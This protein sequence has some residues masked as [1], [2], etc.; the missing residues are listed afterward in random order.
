[1]NRD[2]FPSMNPAYNRCFRA[3]SL[4]LGLVAPLEAYERGA[5][6][7]MSRHLDLIQLADEL[8]YRAVWLRDIPF[9][10]QGFGD[11]G[12][13]YDPWV[14]L[15]L[16]GAATRNIGLGIAS[17]ILPLR[18]PAHVAKSAAT[19]DQLSGGR[20]LLGVASGDR[21]AEYPAMNISFDERSDSFHQSFYYIRQAA[22]SYPEFES[23][24]GSMNRHLDIIPKPFATKIPMLI[25][26]YSQQ[27]YEWLV[28]HGDGWINYPKN[29]KMQRKQ[30][31]TWRS[32][33]KALELPNK[34]A[35]QPLY[36]DVVDERSHALT[37]IH[38]GI[39]CN[40]PQLISYVR[41]AQENGVNHLI[42][43]LRFNQADI[44]STLRLLAKDVLGIFH[45]TS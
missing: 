37:P 35:I 12:Q 31:E 38:L 14:Y 32:D 19:V 4:S 44:S 34:P 28:R 11:V 17:A 6:P 41:Q 29:S 20:M 43:N 5:A 15:G 36:I 25:T 9:D 39:R 22:A 16:L 33:R 3:G 10:D 24:R 26:G 7:T 40:I 8:G 13:I 2:E 1:M 45:E 42:F 30:I 23:H 18:H 27:S 21:P